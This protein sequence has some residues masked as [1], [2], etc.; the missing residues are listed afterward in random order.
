MSKFEEE[1][2]G[3]VGSRDDARL[4]HSG[5]PTSMDVARL[6]GVS[7][8]T[9]SYVLND[10]PN[11]RISKTT[12]E[13]VRRAARELGYI[14]NEAASAL[15][16]GR[17]D[18]VLLPFFDWP[19]NQSSIAFLQNLA[20]KLDELGYSVMLQF[21]GR[22]DRRATARRIASYH[23]VGVIIL[24]EG[25][26]RKDIDILKKNGVKAILAYGEVPA[27]SL[28]TIRIDFSTVGECAARYLIEKGHRH[29]A[30]IMPRD[31]RIAHLGKQRLQGVNRIA[32]RF[33]V[34]IEC[35]NLGYDIAEA[36]NL[37][38]IWKRGPRP[39]GVFTYNDDYGLMLMSAL[40]DAGLD[41]PG[42][43]A[44]VGCDDLPYCEMVRPRLTSINFASSN[45][46]KEIAT[47][48]DCMI[49]GCTPAEA[50]NTTVSPQVVVR[51]SG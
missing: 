39:S 38:S 45:L 19:Y 6:A 7:R 34:Q 44:L 14:P 20:L 25:L 9:V 8:A 15:R 37:A 49:K 46:D 17:S 28:P 12:K 2:N 5:P 3:Q 29:I 42:D 30:V 35:V 26:S 21:F 27:V 40:S 41:V 36:A 31:P 11:S 47:Y 51:E 43:V 4:L 16:S 50:P 23:P 22:G 1:L 10:V 48:F 33:E 18:L 24:S 32:G 13:R